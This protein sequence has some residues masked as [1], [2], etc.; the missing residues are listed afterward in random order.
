M[1]P[2]DPCVANKLVNCSQTTV[3]WHVDYLK[4]SQ[5]EE[6]FFTAFCICICGIFGDGTKIARGKV[7]EYLGMDMDWSQY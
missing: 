7:H 6:D 5:I 4:I 3:C 1:N 2:Y